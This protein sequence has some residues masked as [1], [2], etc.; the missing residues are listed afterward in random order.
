VKILT[1][2]RPHN[3]SQLV[4]AFSS[5]HQSAKA[6]QFIRNG[7]AHNHVQTLNDIQMP[8]SAYVVFPIGHP[9]HAMFWTEPRSSDFLVTHA[10]QELKDAGFAA[11]T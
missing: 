4:S 3:Y 5:G 1:R 10:I 7:A 11:I 2:L 9:T 6:L 8:H